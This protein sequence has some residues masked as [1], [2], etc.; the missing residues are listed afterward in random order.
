MGMDFGVFQGSRI[1]YQVIQVLD[2]T[3][4]VLQD[5]I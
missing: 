1:C 3:V 4:Q 2:L 5:G